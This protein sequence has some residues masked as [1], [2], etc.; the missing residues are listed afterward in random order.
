M[1]LKVVVLCQNDVFVI[2]KNIKLLSEMNEIELVGIVNIKHKGALEN[3]KSLFLK[4]FGIFQVF[5]LALIQLLYKLI[6]FIDKLFLYKLN[7]FKSLQS[8]AAISNSKYKIIENPNDKFFLEWLKAKN[9]EL[10]VSFSA[11]CIFQK[12]L[13]SLPS[14]GCINLHCSLLP[15]F[16]GLLPSFWTL[17]ENEEYIGA[18]VHAMDTK[19]DNGSILDQIAIKMPEKATMFSVINI[20][21]TAGGHLMVKVIKDIIAGEV[22]YSVNNIPK[23]GYYH[24]PTLEQIHEFRRKGGRLI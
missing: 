12:D 22:N 6:D 14:H 2:P 10:I 3:K 4:G 8:I 17:F 7:F 16:P 5:K 23:N 15:K 20:T 21:K 24:W 19:I 1:K 9:I 18:S 13:L 11:P